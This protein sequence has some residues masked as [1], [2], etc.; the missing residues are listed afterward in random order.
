MG[1]V[2]KRF[3]PEGMASLVAAI[4]VTGDVAKLPEDGRMEHME[5]VIDF[6]R[7][8]VLE[9]AREYYKVNPCDFDATNETWRQEQPRN[10]TNNLARLNRG[11]LR[12]SLP[13]E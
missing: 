12:H 2:S 1:K 10:A 4:L 3:H 11:N 9:L 6:R 7:T 13:K 5:K 8:Q